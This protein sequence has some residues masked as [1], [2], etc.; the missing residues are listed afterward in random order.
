MEEIYVCSN[1]VASCVLKVTST[2][3]NHTATIPGHC[4]Y[5]GKEALFY[6]VPKD[7]LPRR[8]I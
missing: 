6:Y 2:D 7:D 5:S 1:C 3:L 8:T 4:P